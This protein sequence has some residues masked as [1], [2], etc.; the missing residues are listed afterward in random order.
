MDQFDQDVINSINDNRMINELNSIKPSLPAL[1]KGGNISNPNLESNKNLWNRGITNQAPTALGRLVNRIGSG[2][3]FMVPGS[4][5]HRAANRHMYQSPI[6]IPKNTEPIQPPAAPM[7]TRTPFV[8]VKFDPVQRERNLRVGVDTALN[9]EV[10]EPIEQDQEI[11]N[12]EKE[13]MYRNAAYADKVMKE[14]LLGA[15]DQAAMRRGIIDIMTQ[16]RTPAQ[17]LTQAYGQKAN[18]AALNAM[19]G[20]TKN[21]QFTPLDFTQGDTG[22]LIRGQARIQPALGEKYMQEAAKERMAT[23]LARPLAESE[24]AQRAA[25]AALFGKQGELYGAQALDVPAASATALVKALNP[26]K[27]GND[28]TTMNPKDYF[29]MDERGQL[30]YIA[31]QR[32]GNLEDAIKVMQEYDRRRQ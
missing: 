6:A 16:L 5:E 13:R 3:G 11:P 2:L 29:A 14:N 20:A 25:Q 12:F 7:P 10:Q 27:S 32:T 4:P 28:N 30:G 21:T 24:I 26:A 31:Y 17:N 23:E 18:I 8:P 19:G 22:Q 15:D 9:T 1:P